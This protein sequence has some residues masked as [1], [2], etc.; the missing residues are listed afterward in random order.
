MISFHFQSIGKPG[1]AH[2]DLKSKNILVK[3]DLSCVVADFGLAVL[4]ETGK[5]EVS[6]S[7]NQTRVGTKRYMSPEALDFSLQDATTFEAYR[8]ADMYSFSLIMW[9]VLRR[10]TFPQEETDHFAL[11]FH[12]FV[13]PDP[14]FDEMNRVVCERKLR[15]AIYEKWR[16]HPVIYF[17]AN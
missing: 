12:E 7:K 13:G 8:M 15:P 16:R 5:D 10:T 3:H 1:I 11:P 9:E 2:R 17:L 14:D 4:Q 6:I